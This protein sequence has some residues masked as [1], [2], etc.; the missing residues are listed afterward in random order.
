MYVGLVGSKH[1]ASRSDRVVARA[2]A[3]LDLWIA[4]DSHPRSALAPRVVGPAVV[5]AA[6]GG[7]HYLKTTYRVPWLVAE[8]DKEVG[9]LML[10]VDAA[11]FSSWHAD[12]F[13]PEYVWGR[14]VDFL[15]VGRHRGELSTY[16]GLWAKAKLAPYAGELRTL[17]QLRAGRYGFAGSLP[18]DDFSI[19]GV[20][21]RRMLA[22]S[23]ARDHLWQVDLM[24]RGLV[25][26]FRR[27]VDW[28]EDN[29]VRVILV[30]YP[31]TDLYEA[32]VERI[33]VRRRV[34]RL[35]IEPMVQRGH[36]YFDDHDLLADRHDLFSDPHHLNQRGRLVYSKTMR[37]RL[38]SLGIV[39][40]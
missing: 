11:S 39:A 27:L 5:N 19:Y 20:P 37:E 36:L 22:R 4:G 34:A 12:Q 7:E 15:E 30:S 33:G 25:W 38:V 18:G 2:P 6:V 3:H 1:K 40:E 10:P 14:Y 35:I 31:V 32:W 16:A 21:H 17:N 23:Q 9:A 8:H 28:A 29:D 13:G 24:D 26:G